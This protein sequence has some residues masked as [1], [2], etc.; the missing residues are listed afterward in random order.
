MPQILVSTIRGGEVPSAARVMANAF[1]NTPRFRFLL[2]NDAQRK[3]K[4]R[5]YWGAVI[6]AGLHSS[7][8]IQVA[9]EEPNGL[10]LGV[11]IWEPSGHSKHSAFTLLRSGSGRRPSGSASPP[12]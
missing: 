2:P 9:R 6:R 7:G 3:A 11:A 4:L 5:W 10:P 12:A 1:A 8:V